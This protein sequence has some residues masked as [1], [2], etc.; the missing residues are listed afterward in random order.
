MKGQDIFTFI[1]GLVTDRILPGFFRQGISKGTEAVTKKI[2]TAFKRPPF[3]DFIRVMLGLKPEG[4]QKIISFLKKAQA[5]GREDDAVAALISMLIHQEDGSLNTEESF[6]ILARL[7]QQDD[8]TLF[9]LVEAARRNPIFQHLLR[10]LKYLREFA[11]HEGED[12]AFWAGVV[13]A[14]IQDADTRAKAHV[15][16][17][18]DEKEI[19]GWGKF[20]K[21][22]LTERAKFARLAEKRFR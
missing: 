11:E 2:E 15:E 10:N 20:K 8:E 19:R 9:Q 22:R 14:A 4:T 13:T 18:M 3:S 1:S 12:I 6:K 7:A 17:R 16:N 21:E 5:D